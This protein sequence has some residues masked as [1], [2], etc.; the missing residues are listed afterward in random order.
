MPSPLSLFGCSLYFKICRYAIG[1]ATSRGW[2]S[3][4]GI[5][6]ALE[7]DLERGTLQF[8]SVAEKSFQIAAIAV[9]HVLQRV[10][11]D[12]DARRVGAALV[13][14]TQLRPD[15]PR[16]RRLLPGDRGPPPP[17]QTPCW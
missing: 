4:V 3:G 8:E 13:R 6:P 5:A 14:I 12:D 11:V 2:R 9:G 15:E 1:L 16:P 10:A 7:L 17:G